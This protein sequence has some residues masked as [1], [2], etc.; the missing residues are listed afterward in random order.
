MN[1][2]VFYKVA[3]ILKKTSYIVKWARENKSEED[4]EEIKN[5]TMIQCSAAY[6]EI[7]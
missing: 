6:R 2:T 5:N 7:Q 3:Y 4:Q 1:K